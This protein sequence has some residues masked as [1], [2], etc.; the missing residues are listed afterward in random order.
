MQQGDDELKALLS[1]TSQTLQLKQL[2]IPGST[3]EIYCD[4]STGTVRLYVPHALR[5]NVFLAVHNLSPPGIRATTKIISK[6]FVWTSLNKDI[7][8]WPRICIPCQRVKIQRH[9]NSERSFQGSRC[10]ISPTPFGYYWTPSSIP[11]IFLLLIALRPLIVF[12]VGQRHILF[13]I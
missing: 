4:I 1:A 8:S 11:R 9:T 3:T 6:R 12:L 7:P 13:P 5:R 2:R 10:S